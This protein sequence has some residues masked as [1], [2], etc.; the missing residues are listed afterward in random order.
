MW[1][2][3]TDGA[4]WKD[5]AGVR[6]SVLEQRG[7]DAPNGV[8]SIRSLGFPPLA[9]SREQVVRYEPPEHFAYVILSGSL[10]VK[11]YRADVQLDQVEGGTLIRWSGSFAPAIPGTGALMQAVTAKI[12]ARFAR[13]AAAAAERDS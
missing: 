8:G 10:P 9:G 4:T 6:R 1:R 7:E 2:L 3:L 5:W 13:L 11:D 12:I